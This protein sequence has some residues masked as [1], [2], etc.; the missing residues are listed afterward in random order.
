MKKQKMT[1]RTGQLFFVFSLSMLLASCSTTMMLNDNLETGVEVLEV[2][3][4]SG[5]MPGQKLVFG[6]YVSSKVER[7]IAMAEAETYAVSSRTTRDTMQFNV[8]GPAGNSSR[9]FCL[10]KKSEMSLPIAGDKYQMA[11]GAQNACFG[12]IVL[13]EGSDWSFT[14]ANPSPIAPDVVSEGVISNGQ[15]AI[16]FKA[17]QQNDKGKQVEGRVLGFEFWNGK[18]VVGAVELIGGGRIIIK[19]SLPQGMKSLI[20]TIAATML[21]R[22]DMNMMEN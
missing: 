13:G 4:R 19:K 15:T 8:F 10:S 17:V 6:D 22:Y 12:K 21:L 9:V 16:S 18:E 3:G 2:K 7:K 1:I 11:V 20:A 14:I 5:G